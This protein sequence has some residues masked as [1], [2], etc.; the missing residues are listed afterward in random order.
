MAVLNGHPETIKSFEIYTEHLVVS[1]QLIHM[2]L[3]Q[4]TNIEQFCRP[5]L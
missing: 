3:Q 1:K 4:N 2:V 5:T